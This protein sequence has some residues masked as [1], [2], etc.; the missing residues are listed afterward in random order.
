[1]LIPS[2]TCTFLAGSPEPALRRPG[3]DVFLSNLFLS[4]NTQVSTLVS[5][6]NHGRFSLAF[7]LF[8]IQAGLEAVNGIFL[9]FLCRRVI[10]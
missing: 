8:T 6:Y 1:M 4:S 2:R 3:R 10:G 5:V 9:C 7:F